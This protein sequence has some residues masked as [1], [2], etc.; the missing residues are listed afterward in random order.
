M[1]QGASRRDGRQNEAARGGSHGGILTGCDVLRAESFERLRGSKVGL[2][3][4][5][6]SV[7]RDLTHLADA[8]HG[9]TTVHSPPLFH[10]SNLPRH[11]R[12]PFL[13]PP[14]HNHTG[15]RHAWFHGRTPPTALPPLKLASRAPSLASGAPSLASRAPS[16]RQMPCMVSQLCT[17]H[18]SSTSQTCPLTSALPSSSLHPTITQADAMHGST[19][20]HPQPPFRVSDGSTAMHSLGEMHPLS[21]RVEVN[22]MHG[23]TAAHP[24]PPF[25]PPNQL[26]CFSHLFSLTL[27]PS[28]PQSHRQ[29]PCMADAMHG[30]TKYYQQLLM[31]CMADAIHGFTAVHSQAPFHLVAIFGPEHGFRGTAQAGKSESASK[32]PKTGLPIFDLYGK[33]SQSIAKCFE[34]SGADTIVFDIQDVGARFY[35]FIWTLY[36]CLVAAA[37]CPSIRRFLVLDRPN[38]LGGVVVDG[39]ITEPQHASFVGRKAIPLRHG[40]TVGELSL[41]FLSE[42][43]P[44]DPH[45]A[46]LNGGGS[47]TSSSSSSSSSGGGTTTTRNSSGGGSSSSGSSQPFAPAFKLEVVQ[48]EGWSRSSSPFFPFFPC[49]QPLLS[50]AALT[51]RSPAPVS[52][53]PPSPSPSPSHSASPVTASFKQQN[54]SIEA[55]SS[56]SISP[57]ATVAALLS[58]ATVAGAT[59]AGATVPTALQPL[60]W[61]PPSPNMPTPTTALV[62]AGTCLI[63]RCGE[64]AV[65]GSEQMLPGMPCP[66]PP[67]LVSM[68]EVWLRRC[69]GPTVAQHARTTPTTA[70]VYAGV[71]LRK[72]QQ[73]GRAAAQ[74]SSSVAAKP[75]SRVAAKPSSSAAEKLRVPASSAPITYHRRSHPPAPPPPPVP[76]TTEEPALPQSPELITYHRRPIPPPKPPKSTPPTPP[77]PPSSSVAHGTRSHGAALPLALVLRYT[78]I[79]PPPPTGG[80]VPSTLLEDRHEELSRENFEIKSMDASSA[81]LQGRLKETVFMDRPEGFP[82][83]FPPNTVWKLNRPVYGL[84]QAPREWHNKVKEVLL[85]LDFH[86]STADPTLFIRRHSEPFYI[87][88]YV[89][90]F[91]LVA[92]DSA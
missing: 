3:A 45:L 21:H 43:L 52:A 62:Y 87:L 18:L 54:V 47:A 81:F 90:D 68:S 84:K 6:T 58:S 49:P 83:E 91:I 10:L 4:N 24:Q 42:F 69:P 28:I 55:P 60:L 33:D 5:A 46:K 61:V 41:L 56:S 20:A 72:V 63:E 22:A 48:M 29:M 80:D 73:R 38:P 53:P 7:L 78:A 89:D 27:L 2:I 76:P 30:S 92:K 32:D 85:S 16:H 13:F 59:A 86:P 15:R 23:S 70:L 19:A 66:C 64:E 88:V 57:P 39:P 82:G 11:F 75:S 67:L 17:P 74:P 79:T 8:M 50:P 14:S 71:C 9:F 36:D 37:L 44:P 26:P 35:T 65:C 40:M 25:P 12:S 51:S 1:G 31:P 34:A 77:A